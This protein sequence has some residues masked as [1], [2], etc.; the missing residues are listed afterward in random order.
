[1]GAALMADDATFPTGMLAFWNALAVV[2]VADSAL[3]PLGGIVDVSGNGLN[4]THK[5]GISGGPTYQATGGYVG[6]P[7]IF[8]RTNTQHGAPMDKRFD[9]NIGGGITIFQ[10]YKGEG[11]GGTIQ[12]TANETSSNP[13]VGIYGGGVL[14]PSDKTINAF[15]VDNPGNFIE[16]VG[17]GT[18]A[19]DGLWHTAAVT[20]G[21][22]GSGAA[23]LYV[24][25]SL[26]G[27]GDWS[28]PM[29]FSS[30]SFFCYPNYEIKADWG[31]YY[32]RE[33][34]SGEIRR[35]HNLARLS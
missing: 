27:V 18:I 22:Y 4:L 26:V 29:T 1:M 9:L 33:L 34:S 24:D 11:I 16:I 20:V 28:A 19:N 5:L 15:L 12:Y 7:Y 25:G 2:G 6:G 31:M 21:T 13:S 32:Q 10:S 23:K 35:L 3:I 8:G 30:G 14:H 17:I